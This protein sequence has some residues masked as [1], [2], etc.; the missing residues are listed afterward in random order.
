MEAD[1][2]ETVAEA[3]ANVQLGRKTIRG[4]AVLDPFRATGELAHLPNRRLEKGC[5]FT[6]Q[7]FR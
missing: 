7:P 6:A 2:I 5:A 4:D 3:I 1:L